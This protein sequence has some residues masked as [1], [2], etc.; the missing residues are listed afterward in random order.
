MDK[1]KNDK[2]EKLQNEITRAFD[3]LRDSLDAFDAFK[4][5]FVLLHYKRFDVEYETY[6]RASQTNEQ[7]GKVV[8]DLE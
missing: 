2:T 7:R 6:A 8:K 3:M 4:I 5:V 1:T